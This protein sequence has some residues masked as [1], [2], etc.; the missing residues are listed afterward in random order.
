[1]AVAPEL[2][3]ASPPRLSAVV[4]TTGS[5]D[6]LRP[7]I[8]ALHPSASDLGIEIIA[9][10][11]GESV[12]PTRRL[13]MVRYVVAPG[14]NV[15]TSRAVGAMVA[16]G[17]L[18]ALLEDHS[19]PDSCWAAEVLSA[20]GDNPH[21]DALV[22]SIAPSPDA[23]IWELALFTLTFGPFLGVSEP[24]RDRLPVPGHV[25]FRRSLLPPTTPLPGWLEYELL[26]RLVADERIAMT[27]TTTSIH[28]QPVRWRALL[29]SFHSGRVYAGSRFDHAMR[30][31]VGELRRLRTELPVVWRQTLAARR[32]SNGGL[33]GRRCSTCLAALVVSNGMGQLVGIASRGVGASASQLE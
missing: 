19:I 9:V 17:D 22:H 33:L 16:T 23:G 8:E 12:E 1:M 27:T 14:D 2:I 30:T 5:W 21:V 7:V 32:R 13:P 18:I 25:S 28:V 4:V 31:R 15:F 24:P 10:S 11:S 29:M 6:H 26:G 3:A 20:W